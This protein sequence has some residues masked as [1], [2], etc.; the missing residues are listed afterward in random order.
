M[1]THTSLL[2][3]FV[4]YI[5]AELAEGLLYISTPFRT[6]V[7]PCA[8]GCGNKVVTPVSPADWQLFYDGDTVSSRRT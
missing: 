1:I 6:V 8:C 2:H 4:E 5:P 7:H 3:E